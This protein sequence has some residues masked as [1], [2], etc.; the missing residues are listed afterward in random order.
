LKYAYQ[1]KQAWRLRFAVAENSTK[2]AKY[3]KREQVD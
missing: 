2:I 1:N 3:M